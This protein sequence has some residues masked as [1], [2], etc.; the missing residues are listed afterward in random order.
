MAM[1]RA[2][3]TSYWDGNTVIVT[4]SCANDRTV[5]SYAIR[6]E[7]DYRQIAHEFH[8]TSTIHN[9][10]QRTEVRQQRCRNR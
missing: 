8:E 5:A 10:P 7:K 6:D 4:E 9:T 1:W 3:G 2:L